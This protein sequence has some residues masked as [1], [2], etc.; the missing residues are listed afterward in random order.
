MPEPPLD[1]AIIGAGFSGLAAAIA[2]GDDGWNY[3]LIERGSSVGG[4]WRDTRYPGAACDIPSLLYCLAARPNPGWSSRYASQPEIHAY[5]QG[6]AAGLGDRLLLDTPVSA[7]RWTGDQWH[8]ALASGGTMAA[9]AVVLALGPHSRPRIPD[10]PGLADF[11][12]RW[13]HSADWDAGTDKGAPEPSG[14]VLI[15]GAGASAVQLV[16]ALAGRADM[17]TV[18]QRSPAW[19]LPRGNRARAGWRRRLGAAVPIIDRAERAATYWL[20]EGV[21][22]G[23]LGNRA[24]AAVVRRVALAKLTREV[25]DPRVRAALNP[26]YALGCKRVMVSDDYWPAFNRRDVQLV[27]GAVAGFDATGAI[28]ADGRHIACDEV[29]FATGYDVADP[30][31]FLPVAGLPGHA[32]PALW[33]DGGARAY[34]GTVAAGF[35]NLAMLLG[36]NSGL[37]HSSAVHVAESQVAYV[38]QWLRSI[39]AH[40]AIAP[41]ATVEA[42]YNDWLAAQLPGTVWASGC[43]S[44]YLD[45]AGRNAVIYPGLTAGFRRRLARFREADYVVSAP[46]A[47]DAS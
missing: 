37:S 24:V 47:A 3:R 12:G 11:R 1:V 10:F 44:W 42:A 30:V 39:A 13:R 5:L 2:I 7:L 40:G 34:L 4:V 31:G 43:T 21:G 46:S 33:Q 23:N 26:D 27:R 35:P 38:R 19:V 28:L 36:P 14:H 41:K 8:L 25:A 20:L 16:P 6:V 29:V 18:V 15:V 32:L 17:L 9:R 22:L 45:A